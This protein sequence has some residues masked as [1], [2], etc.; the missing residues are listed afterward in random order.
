[1]VMYMMQQTAFGP[2]SQQKLY[3]TPRTW[4]EHIYHK[5]AR[6]GPTPHF[7]RD[8]LGAPDNNSDNKNNGILSSSSHLCYNRGS[9]Y[10]FDEGPQDL[11]VRSPPKLVPYG[12]EG[13]RV[14]DRHGSAVVGRD[15]TG[16]MM[17]PAAAS[18]HFTHD[19]RVDCHDRCD[20]PPINVTDDERLGM[21][22][23]INYL[24]N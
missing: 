1:M 10:T 18:H 7:I 6:G 17:S 5:P 20:S 22:L 14:A 11:V 15:Q 23:M 4:H 8:I 12:L 19:A 3:T 16:A 24:T 2:V 13:S 21:Q 9:P